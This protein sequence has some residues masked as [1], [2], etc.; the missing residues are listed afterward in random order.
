MLNN[1]HFPPDNISVAG[2]GLLPSENDISG[3]THTLDTQQKNK[4]STQDL[5]S[6]MQQG[7]VGIVKKKDM[8]GELGKI[9]SQMPV[10]H[11]VQRNVKERTADTP[12]I[13][14]NFF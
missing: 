7:N 13:L 3:Q 2:P 1:I 10:I 5:V 4:K 14:V 12:L 9:S 6:N 8:G 11:V